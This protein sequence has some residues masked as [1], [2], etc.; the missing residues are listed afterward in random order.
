MLPIVFALIPT[1]VGTGEW[2]YE[3]HAAQ[4]DLLTPVF[5]AMLIGLNNSGKKGVLL[6]GKSSF[7]SSKARKY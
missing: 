5:T 3:W 4:G 1:I 2:E 7:G 6:F